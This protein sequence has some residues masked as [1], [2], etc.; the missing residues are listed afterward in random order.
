ML[1][2]QHGHAQWSTFGNGQDGSRTINANTTLDAAM[3]QV[4][5]YASVA[6]TLPRREATLGNKN[7]YSFQVGDRVLVIDLDSNSVYNTHRNYDLATVVSVSPTTVTVEMVS[8]LAFNVPTGAKTR[9]Q[10]IEV[11]QFTNLTLNGGNLTCEAWNSANGYGGILAFN[12]N[13]TF[14]FNGGTIDTRYKGAPGH[15]GAIG[16]AAGQP[17]AGSEGAGGAAGAGRGGDAAYRPDYFT[18]GLTGAFLQASCSSSNNYIPKGGDGGCGQSHIDG[19][20]PLN[21][22]MSEIWKKAKGATSYLSPGNSGYGGRGGVGAGAGGAGGGGGGGFV[23]GF[24][25]SLGVAGHGPGGDGGLSGSGGGTVYIRAFNIDLTGSAS[26]KLIFTDGDTGYSAPNFPVR[27]PNGGIGGLGGDGGDGGKNPGPCFSSLM[28]PAG[29]GGGHGMAGD[30]AGGGSGGQGGNGGAVWIKY[31]TKHASFSVSKLSVKGGAGGKMGQ[32]GGFKG[33]P[34]NINPARFGKMGLPGFFCSTG[35]PCASPSIKQTVAISM[36]ADNTCLKASCN[37]DSVYAVLARMTEKSGNKYIRPVSGNPADYVQINGNYLFA[38][39]FPNSPSSGTC[40]AHGS[41]MPW[42]PIK[43]FSC[44]LDTNLINCNLPFWNTNPLP[45][46]TINYI[47]F[48]V[49]WPGLAT[50]SN[51]V[52]TGTNGQSCSYGCPGI[53]TD[54]N[55]IHIPKDG[56]DGE[57]GPAGENGEAD[58]PAAGTPDEDYSD[59]PGAPA[60]TAITGDIEKISDVRLYPNPTRDMLYLSFNSKEEGLRFN[61]RI[62]SMEGKTQLEKTERVSRGN[63]RISI[64]VSKLPSGTYAVIVSDLSDNKTNAYRFVKQ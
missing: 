11:P 16:G 45:V 26:G 41:F 50:Y 5:N 52:L 36:T 38:Y 22:Q 53:R 57:P 14:Q 25:G 9:T 17:I 48:S 51:G 4:T 7:S 32:K 19:D 35:C 3:A 33:D 31:A 37:C 55:I 64:N 2:P 63:R 6:G 20:I 56:K 13:G 39:V 12:V 27:A 59:N 8:F 42:Q 34:L 61:I 44:I 60:W 24:P 43:I 49:T 21:P 23:S 15:V 28:Y 18:Q 30:G 47:P 1:I 54:G 62:V 40:N 10:I 58:I 46:G 29:G